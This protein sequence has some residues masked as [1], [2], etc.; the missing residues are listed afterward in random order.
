MKKDAENRFWQ[1]VAR[2]TDAAQC[3][4]WI[5][6]RTAD[7]YG[8]YNHK[9]SHRT[10]WELTNGSIAEGLCVCHTCDNP[11]CCNP[12][13]LFLGTPRDNAQDATRKGHMKKDYHAPVLVKEKSTSQNCQRYTKLLTVLLAPEQHADLA[14][15]AAAEDTSMGEIVRQAIAA[16]LRTL[17]P[18]TTP[19]PQEAD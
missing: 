14:A 19:T 4:N 11:P 6:Y 9:S 2:T 5:G 17:G 8:Q 3:W 7:G 18:V 15:A 10:A 13:H 16:Y 12:A 1:N